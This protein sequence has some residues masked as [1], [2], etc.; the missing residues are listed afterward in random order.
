MEKQHANRNFRLFKRLLIFEFFFII[1]A[2]SFFA[3]NFESQEIFLK[4]ENLQSEIY[5][6]N[7]IKFVAIIKE[8]DAAEVSVVNPKYSEPVIFKTL[9]K[10]S[11]KESGGTKI[12]IWLEF[13]QSG[14]FFIEPLIIFANQKKYEIPYADFF[15]NENPKNLNPEFLVEFSNGISFSEENFLDSSDS[16]FLFEIPEGEKLTLE[17]FVKNAK[18]I[19]NFYWEIPEN[20]IF[21]Q[22]QDEKNLQNEKEFS[23]FS[24][25]KI[26]AFEWTFLKSG[27]IIFPDFSCLAQKNSGEEFFIKSFPAKIL[28]TNSKNKVIQNFNENSVFEDA[29]TEIQQTDLQTELS[30]EEKIV[31]SQKKLQSQKNL[32]LILGILF[33][34]IFILFLIFSVFCRKKKSFWIFVIFAFVFLILSVCFTI[35]KNQNYAI[36]KKTFIHSIPE[37]NAILKNEIDSGTI[38]KIKNV[39]EN[40]S[41]VTTKNFHGYIKNT[42]IIE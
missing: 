6:Q 7:E 35:L 1:F 25:N 4:P 39:T 33:F 41:F 2:N 30:D 5:S 16:D 10:T 28:V 3:E 29:F 15:V 23:D 19:T 9:R 32:L 24:K 12:E 36:S 20:S 14:K 31:L 34:V 11:D 38:L 37:E 40:W 21:V 18:K 13:L 27:E 22:I 26:A 42:E 17:I 8:F